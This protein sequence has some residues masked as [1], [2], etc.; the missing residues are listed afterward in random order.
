MAD[1][2]I[3]TVDG[4][5]NSEM[6]EVL[7]ASPM[8]A[9]RLRL[10]FD[11]SPDIFTI[12]RLKYKDNLHLGF[13]VDGKLKGFASLGFYDAL[14]D[15]VPETV[16]SIYH[17]YILPEARGRG[18]P[19]RAGK[20]MADRVA[21]TNARCGLSV[22]LKGNRATESYMIKQYD[23]WAPQLA[24]VGQ[25]VVKSILFSRRIRNHTSYTVSHAGDADI[26]AMVRL[27]REEQLQR[28][29]GIPISE[30]GFLRNLKKRGLRISDYY[31]ARNA[32]GEPRG[33]CLAWDCSSFRRTRILNYAL[34]FLPHLAGYRLLSKVM[35]MAPFPKKGE[36]FRELTVTDTA[37]AG[38]D[39]SVLHALLTEVYRRHH[40]GS[41]HFMNWASCADD[42]LLKAADGFWHKDIVSHLVMTTHDKRLLN[43]TWRLPF[44]DIAYL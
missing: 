12:G 43:R 8:Q 34:S 18:L 7:N 31:I 16:Y 20:L 44:A 27:L 6:L 25:L 11:K 29:F 15:G 13:L 2:K 36:C 42:P 9:G 1:D 22:T 37:A 14:L 28:D 5:Y 38:R 33:V 21:E 35:R 32:R 41:Y 17:F 30:E 40:N 4:S 3:I 24:T 39:P 23:D 19:V 26:P 10:C